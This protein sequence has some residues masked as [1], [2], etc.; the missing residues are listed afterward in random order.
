MSG[1]TWE[2]PN[3]R[4]EGSPVD[5]DYPVNVLLRRQKEAL[6]SFP[7]PSLKYYFEYIYELGYEEAPKYGPMKTLFVSSTTQLF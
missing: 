1:F 3:T 5:L 4:E 6:A 7:T 2:L